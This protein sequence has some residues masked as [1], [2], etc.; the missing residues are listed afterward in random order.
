MPKEES[1]DVAAWRALLRAHSASLRAIEAALADAGQVPL[2]WYDV[3]LELSAAPEERLRMQ[4]V[5]DRVLL[6]RTR[7]SRLVDE[8]AAAGLVRREA[9][10]ADRRASFVVLTDEG[11]RRLRAAAPVYRRGIRDHFGRHLDEAQLHDVRTALQ[12]VAAAEE[13]PEAFGP[14]RGLR[15]GSRMGTRTLGSPEGGGDGGDVER[16]GAGHDRRRP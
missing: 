1:A 10:P 3:L 8:I 7:V 9:D 6:S 12:T 16:T 13:G 15:A 14:R 4:Q 11:R 5:S 2:T